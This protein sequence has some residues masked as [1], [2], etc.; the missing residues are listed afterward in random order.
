VP[1][2]VLDVNVLVTA[3]LS[4]RG[5]PAR[6]LDE[7]RAGAFE[8][9][10][11]EALLRELANAFDKSTLRGK[12]ARVDITVLEARLRND[13]TLMADP[14][15]VERVIPRHAADDYLVAL[16]RAGDADVIVTGDRHILD[17]E[18]LTPRALK[19]AP[20]LVGIL[21]IP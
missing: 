10:V 18:G 21:T 11:S 17:V 19:P 12:I 1:R 8:L 4:P 13:A 14:S 3:L 2:V 20:F 9:I 6:I 16:A 7:W 5:V 15:E